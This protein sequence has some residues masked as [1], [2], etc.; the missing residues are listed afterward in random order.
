MSLLHVVSF[1]SQYTIFLSAFCLFVRVCFV[2]D[3]EGGVFIV[4]LVLLLLAGLFPYVYC[5]K[6][7]FR[8]FESLKFKTHTQ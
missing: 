8:C 1:D 4:S 2:D 6:L 7:Y 5:I 3:D